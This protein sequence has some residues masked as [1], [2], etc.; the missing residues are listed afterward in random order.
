MVVV[1]EG[2]LAVLV[3]VVA[4][5]VEVEVDEMVEEVGEHRSALLWFLT[6]L[7][8]S[9]LLEVEVEPRF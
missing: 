8:L 1:L 5:M 3:E 4:G 6:W 7:E 2:V 9:Q